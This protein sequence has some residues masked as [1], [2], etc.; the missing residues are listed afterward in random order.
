MRTYR[1]QQDSISVTALRGSDTTH[2]AS[3]VA[4]NLRQEQLFNGRSTMR[5]RLLSMISAIALGA[6]GLYGVSALSPM[7]TAQAASFD[8][9]GPDDGCGSSGQP[10]CSSSYGNSRNFTSTD[11]T[12]NVTV[13]AWSMTGNSTGSGTG[14][15]DKSQDAFLGFY[16][17]GL[18][19]TNR[20]PISNGG[21][22]VVSD[23]TNRGNSS[24][25]QNYGGDG[26]GTFSQHTMDN[27]GRL[28]FM[29]F[30]FNK[31]VRLDSIGMTAFTCCSLPG[32]PD[33]DIQVYIGN[34]V[35]GPDS[36]SAIT[37]ADVIAMI[38]NKTLI[39]LDTLLDESGLPNEPFTDEGAIAASRTASFS[40][41]PFGNLIVLMPKSDEGLDGEDMIKVAA[42][43]VTTN[44]PEISVPEPMTGALFA[45]SLMGLAWMRRR[46]ARKAPTQA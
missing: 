14:F 32:D 11:P 9:N 24:A 2:F 25:S 43:D 34:A 17:G 33:S 13:R 23:A 37:D 16:S 3:T 31:S 44:V 19:V 26:T 21:T 6:T 28:D 5:A 12:L 40:N 36:G 42:M 20:D 29:S 7:N 22:E 30:F 38:A 4:N 8:F 45:G 46:A 1:V 39:D 10:A 15:N 27:V 35:D 18:G 41:L